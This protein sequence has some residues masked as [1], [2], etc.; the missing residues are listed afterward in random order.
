MPM[1]M[2]CSAAVLTRRALRGAGFA[3]FL[4]LAPLA[5]LAVSAQQVTDAHA[6]EAAG[7]G[8]LAPVSD[9]LAAAQVEKAAGRPVRGRD[10]MVVAAHPLATETGAQVLETGGTAADA[11]VAVQAVLGLVEPQSSG[12]GGGGF[13]LFWDA[14]QGVLT[15]LDGREAAPMSATPQLFL[16][17]DGQPMGFFEAVV[18][19]RS[20]GV[21]GMP[22]LL[23]QAHERWGRA[24]WAGLLTPAI[25]LAEDGFAVSPRLALLV[26]GD[27]DRLASFPETA[28]YFLPGGQ[29][30]QEGHWLRNPAY[31]ETLQRLA[32]GG[33]DGF[34]GGDTARGLVAAV[35]AAGG[36][37]EAQDL[38]IYRVKD[39]PPVC[40][41]WA[42]LQVCGMG[43]PSSGGLAVAQILGLLAPYDL[44]AS[45]P[46]A[47]D[48]W[49]LI[50][51]ATR[52]AFAD[53]D[54][55]VGDADYLPVPVKGLLAPEYLAGRAALLA[56]DDALPQVTPGDPGFDHAALAPGD[57]LER[58]STTH[59]TIVDSHGNVA[60]LTSSIENAFGS[61][62]MAGGMLLNNQL[63]DFS[64][65][66]HEDGRPLANQAAPGKRPRSSMAPTLVLRDGRPVLALG[67]PGGSRIIPY[68]AKTLIAWRFW[69]MDVQQ[70]VALPHLVNRYGSYDLEAG[71]PAEAMA[72]ALEA[73]G[74]AVKP[75][76][77]TSGLHV[78]EIGPDGLSGGADPRREGVALGG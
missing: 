64:F 55:F 70:A 5:P 66:S 28:A 31:A 53:R 3:L 22:A 17:A 18:G 29:A 73:L 41:D 63:T 42:G 34:Y 9:R 39:R 23:A 6:P 54:R 67:S 58:A 14:G 36:G 48:S 15:T 75:G 2:S 49:R 43:P 35:A 69:G 74:Y 27:A 57:T 37:L 19:G 33:V 51:D 8:L 4:A 32:R 45:G 76:A 1:P 72:P 68:V 50:G 62:L 59:V 60:V 77:L 56:G 52:L 30:V 12:L 46:G 61:R 16:G 44:A 20:V 10:W 78:I 38:A 21:P 13:L 7:A 47:A 65:R 25:T 24:D 26:A 11:L 40:G 71:T